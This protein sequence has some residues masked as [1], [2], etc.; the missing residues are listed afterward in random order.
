MRRVPVNPSANF[1]QGWQLKAA[2]HER[3][4]SSAQTRRR[5]FRLKRKRQAQNPS[6]RPDE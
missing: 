3:R 6:A 4:C 5:N 1:F 2:R